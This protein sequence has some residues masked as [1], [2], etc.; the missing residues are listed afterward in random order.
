MMIR[1]ICKCIFDEFNK[2]LHMRFRLA[3]RS[4]TLDDFEVENKL[5]NLGYFPLLGVKPISRKQY[6]PLSRAYLCVS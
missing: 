5:N 2:K 3:P 6:E 1:P 4:M